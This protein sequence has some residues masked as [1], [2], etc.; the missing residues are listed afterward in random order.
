M[1][2]ETHFTA[3]QQSTRRRPVSLLP[4]SARSWRQAHGFVHTQPKNKTQREPVMLHLCL[5]HSWEVQ[6]S[7]C[8]SVYLDLVG[9]F[10]GDCICF[11]PLEMM[12]LTHIFGSPAVKL[13]PSHGW[14]VVDGTG[15]W[16]WVIHMDL[17][18][19]L[20]IAPPACG[21]HM[22]ENDLLSE[23]EVSVRNEKHVLDSRMVT[24]TT[25]LWTD[26]G[27]LWCITLCLLQVMVV[28]LF[29]MH[30]EYG[31]GSLFN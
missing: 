11:E 23:L 19:L 10:K 31:N 29:N 1:P 6:I 16:G 30:F 22:H 3:A 18:R 9:G 17:P 7:T 13:T 27:Q 15:G 21:R 2:P 5:T 28:Q 12:A 8:M 14:P 24:V 25:I 4:W 26:P 20:N